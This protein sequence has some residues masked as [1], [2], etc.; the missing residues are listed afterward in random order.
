MKKIPFFIFVLPLL[1]ISQ[2]TDVINSNR[3][4]VSIGA[5]SVGTNVVQG[6][7]G[8]FYERQKHELLK[9]NSSIIGTNFLIRYGLLFEPLEIFIEGTFVQDRK[10]FNA[11]TP[12]T[13]LRETDFTKSIVGLKYLIYDPY[14][15][16][17]KNKPNLYSW[18]ANYKIQWKNLIP[19][20]ALYAGVNITLGNNPF[21]PNEKPF[22]PKAMLVTQSHLSPYW[23]FITNIAYNRIGTEDPEWSYILSLTHIL[24]NP[25]WSFFIENQGIDSTRY[26]DVLL[27]SGLVYL[28]NSDFQV[29]ISLGINFK[30]TP[31]RF[32]GGLGISYRLDF[33][34]DKITKTNEEE[35]LKPI[36]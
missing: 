8:L 27:R 18:K 3:P 35:P 28:F 1:A 15:D 9:T 20:V 2:Y 32:F 7:W 19:V 5:Y 23:V 30:E 10:T 22:T 36:E 31:S 29:D 11:S 14:R 33:H 17:E 26:V 6:E 24:R 21:L 13:T 25:R 12:N 16:P 34:K 4:G